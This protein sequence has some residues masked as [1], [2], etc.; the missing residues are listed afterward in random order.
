M[1]Q[2]IRFEKIKRIFFLTRNNFAENSNRGLLVLSQT[3][4]FNLMRF[5]ISWIRYISGLFF[6][7]VEFCIA[8]KGS[9]I[10]KLSINIK[11]NK[12]KVRV[13]VAWAKNCQFNS[14]DYFLEMHIF[15][16]FEGETI[17]IVNCD[18]SENN[19]S[20]FKFKADF[21][22]IRQNLGYD[23]GAYKD[24][25]LLL[26]NYPFE[27]ITLINNSI[28][29]FGQ[30]NSWIQDQEDLAME[31]DGVSGAVESNFPHPH[32]Q[33]FSLSISSKILQAKSPFLN[34]ISN[35][36]TLNRKSGVVRFQEVGF[37]KML[38]KNGINMVSLYP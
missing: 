6:D 4:I 22:I 36:K 24:I 35:L 7:F 1:S 9:R 23:W 28:L 38:S 32:L 2:L 3:I 13:F 19:H 25:L 14:D 15:K 11:A 33:S 31:F 18:C 37:G 12:Q 34:W 17:T 27:T 26:A 30:D 21:L 8:K 5:L 16:N 20:N 29:S 10:S